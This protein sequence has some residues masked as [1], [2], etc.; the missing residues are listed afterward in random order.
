MGLVPGPGGLAAELSEPD[1][2]LNRADLHFRSN[3]V[4]HQ[5]L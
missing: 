4:N 5:R 3:N 1:A 2:L